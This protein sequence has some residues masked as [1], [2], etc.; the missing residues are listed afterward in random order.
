MNKYLL[1]TMLLISTS[2]M[3]EETKREKCISVMTYGYSACLDY[4]GIPDQQ[5]V[6]TQFWFI[7]E[8]CVEFVKRPD[9][10]MGNTCECTNEDCIAL[11]F[12]VLGGDQ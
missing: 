9:K 2:V 12:N 3:A 10:D 6:E 11:E 4:I 8:N 7:R 1:I 5:C